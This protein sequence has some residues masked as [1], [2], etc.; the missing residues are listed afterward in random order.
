M[1]LLAQACLSPAEMEAGESIPAYLLQEESPGAA[2]N[3]EEGEA[4]PGSSQN[5][6]QLQQDGKLQA[7]AP[8]CSFSSP[9]ALCAG[10]GWASWAAG[11]VRGGIGTPYCRWWLELTRCSGGPSTLRQLVTP[12]NSLL[13]CTGLTWLTDFQV[14]N[15]RLLPALLRRT[16]Q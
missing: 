2:G 8:C 12:R 9:R 15:I 1:A 7:E 10:C 6:R 5:L 4:P 3:G 14:S 11:R 13:A 16:G